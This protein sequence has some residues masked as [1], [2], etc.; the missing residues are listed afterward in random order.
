MQK[1]GIRR[2]VV[3]AL[4][5]HVSESAGGVVAHIYQ[6]HDFFAEKLAALTAWNDYLDALVEGRTPADNVVKLEQR[7]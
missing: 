2:E 6:R 3:E 7:A 5:N 1:L 4:I